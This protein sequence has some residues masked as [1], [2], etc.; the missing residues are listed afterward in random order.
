MPDGRQGEI[1]F[2]GQWWRAALVLACLLVSFRPEAGAAATEDQ[3][4]IGVLA[5]RARSNA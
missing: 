2:F 1:R 3:F 5:I 4:K